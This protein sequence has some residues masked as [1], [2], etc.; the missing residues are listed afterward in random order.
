[1]KFWHDNITEKSFEVLQELK[2]RYEFVLIGGWAVYL[3]TKSLKSK[4]IDIIVELKM[5]GEFRAN[6]N[7]VKNSRLRKYE[8][9]FEGFDVDIYVPHFSHLCLPAEEV[10]KNVCMREGFK[11]PSPEILLILKLFAYTQRKGSLKG[12]KDEIDI[13]SLF[14]SGEISPDRLKKHFSEFNL[15]YLKEDLKNLLSSF[16]EVKELNINQ[17]QFADL[18]KKVIKD[19]LDNGRK[20]TKRN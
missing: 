13:I 16:V 9:C 3:Y 8:I 2:R 20:K 5:L 1:M 11:I 17:K 10:L 14:R 6:Y 7:L 4:D 15:E 19:F 18:K 12:K